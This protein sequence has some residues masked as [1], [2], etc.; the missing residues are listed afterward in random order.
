M[1]WLARRLEAFPLA[2]WAFVGLLIALVPAG[3]VQVQLERE[4]RVE[5]TEQLQEE[6]MRFVR[7][8]GQQ[9]ISIIAAA[10]QLLNSMGAHDALRDMQP[11]AECDAFLGRIVAANP[12]YLSAGLF[13]LDG[14]AICVTQGSNR[15]PSQADRG[16]FQA[17]LQTN[18]FHV[19]TFTQDR[20]TGERSLDFAA[21]LQD[22]SGRLTGVMLVSLSIDWLI[23]ALQSV[24]LPADSSA[25]VADRNGVVLARTLDPER[26]VGRPMAPFAQAFL[27]EPHAR[28]IDAPALDGVR[29]I[30]A[31]VPLN[32]EPRGLFVSVGLD[33]AGPLGAMIQEDRRVAV[34]IIGSLLLSFAI[35][36]FVFHTAVERP[37]QRLLVAARRWGAED[38]EARVGRLRGGR[39]FARLGAAFDG[40]AEAVTL[41]EAARQ[42]ATSR[43]Q[44]LAHVAPQIVLMADQAGQV[45]WTNDHWRQITHLDLAESKGDGWLEGIHVDDREVARAAWLSALTKTTTGPDVPFTQEARVC[46]IDDHQWRWHLLTGAPIEDARGVIVAWAMVGVDFHERR[47][48][49]AEAAETAARLRATYESAPAGLCLLD[50]ELRYVAIN[51]MLAETNGKSVDAHIGRTIEEMAP[52]VAEYVAP[53]MR[54]VLET[55][56]PTEGLELRGVVAGEERFWLCS[57]YAVRSADGEITGLSGA[58]V[59]ITTRKRIEASER[60]LSREVDHRAQ[61]ALSVVRG[62]V[63]LSAAEAKGGVAGLVEVL[64]GRIAA[65]G[66]AHNVLAREKWVG[67]NMREIIIQ[68]TA[69]HAAQ[70]ELAGPDLRLHAESAQPLS[71]VVHE[72]VTNAVKHG[73]LSTPKGRLTLRWNVRADGVCLDWMERGGPALEA[74]P[75]RKGFGT[76]LIDANV[77]AQLDGRIEREWDSAGLHAILTLGDEAFS[78]GSIS[79]IHRR[80][81]LLSGRR[82]LIAQDDPKLAEVL[83]TSLGQAGC[84]ICASAQ[85]LPDAL[86][87][88]ERAG[89]L[90]AAIL[91]ASLQ[92]RSTWPLIEMLRRRAGVILLTEAPEGSAPG[93]DLI[94]VLATP[95]TPLGLRETLA[96]ALGRLKMTTEGMPALPGE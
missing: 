73:A 47:Q 92:G 43:M 79:M 84:V 7:L 8:V 9:N 58:V 51:A 76:V 37:V 13:G 52:Q 4:A 50:R 46:R 27:H 25:T 10:Q 78:P 31:I 16:Y 23:R 64:E 30:A 83:A 14:R 5:R 18:A 28:V 22:D 67:A 55:G 38:W 32:E 17:V 80:Q 53:V 57:Y 81:S 89:P 21:P 41:R 71:F 70:V 44:A 45:D 91:G 96:E 33:P 95:I 90:D 36:V 20:S 86:E 74:P 87:A 40:M 69:S 62:L 77:N 6:A 48:V 54:R 15:D 65:M 94:E 82:I 12:R 1:S 75:V 29:R 56:E 59:D 34:M 72:L 42:Q 2:L 26:F 49:E 11:S 66:R 35:A 88:V 61:N 19:G 85:S 39:E 3:I 68:E 60:L 24:P 63:R 93:M